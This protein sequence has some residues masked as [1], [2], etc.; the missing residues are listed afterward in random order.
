MGPKKIN[1]K[2]RLRPRTNERIHVLMITIQSPN[3]KPRNLLD[4]AITTSD[5]FPPLSPERSSEPRER[6]IPEVNVGDKKSSA[7]L[8]LPYACRRIT[9]IA[10]TMHPYCSRCFNVGFERL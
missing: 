2:K 4:S 6:V 3:R 8:H 10:T 5:K 7:E 9:R 1:H